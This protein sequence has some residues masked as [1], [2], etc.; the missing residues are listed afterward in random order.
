MLDRG[1][2][3]AQRSGRA[4][5]TPRSRCIRR[6]PRRGLSAPGQGADRVEANDARGRRASTTRRRWSLMEDEERREQ[7]ECAAN[8]GRLRRIADHEA[9]FTV[10]FDGALRH[11]ATTSHATEIDRRHPTT[12]KGV[13]GSNDASWTSTYRE[14]G[15][16]F[17]HPPGGRGRSRSIAVVFY[18]PEGFDAVT[19]LGDWAGGVFDGTIRVPCRRPSQQGAGAASLR[20]QG[21]PAP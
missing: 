13:N 1:H 7:I 20:D 12:L 21:C 9:D 11:T 3:A 14:Y 5:E 17:G 19:G 10:E 16:L 15:V 18:R 6:Q 2:R 8:A 4:L